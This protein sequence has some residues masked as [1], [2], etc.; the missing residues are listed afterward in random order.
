MRR[1]L[2]SFTFLLLLS[3]AVGVAVAQKPAGPKTGT[4]KA[5]ARPNP[6]AHAAF[7][8]LMFHQVVKQPTLAYGPQVLNH[9]RHFFE[10]SDC[11]VRQLLVEIALT[12]ALHDLDLTNHSS[13]NP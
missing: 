5:P 11:S 13:L 6:G 4:A 9:L 7:V 10:T 2:A 3:A 1:A 8:E 12:A